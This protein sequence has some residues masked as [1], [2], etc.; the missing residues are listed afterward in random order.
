MERRRIGSSQLFYRLDAGC[1]KKITSTTGRQ[2]RKRNYGKSV[3]LLLQELLEGGNKR[4]DARCETKSINFSP[5]SHP[6]NFI[7]LHDDVTHLDVDD[8]NASNISQSVRTRRR[9]G[10]G[11]RPSSSVLSLRWVGAGSRAVRVRVYSYLHLHTYDK[12]VCVYIMPSKHGMVQ[13]G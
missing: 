4:F 7:S 11:T 12:F 9:G 5:A 6:L 3:L 1:L 10:R 8:E 2:S 13:I